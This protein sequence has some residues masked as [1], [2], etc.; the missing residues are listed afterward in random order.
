MEQRQTMTIEEAAAALGVSRHGSSGRARG[1][2]ARLADAFAGLSWFETSEA[3]RG[4]FSG[5]GGLWLRA[6]LTPARAAETALHEC[7]HAYQFALLGAA[8]GDHEHAGR[9]AQAQRY[10]EELRELART[11]A[12]G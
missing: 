3:L 11:I 1:P 4:K 9:E 12:G 6:D 5:T 7:N 10:D 2:A 8:L